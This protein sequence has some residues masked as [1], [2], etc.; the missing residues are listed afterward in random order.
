MAFWKVDRELQGNQLV[1]SDRGRLR[2]VPG[3][4]QEHRLAH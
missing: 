3:G 4:R 2:L 1:Q